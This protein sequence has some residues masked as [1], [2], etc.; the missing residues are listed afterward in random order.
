MSEKPLNQPP[1]NDASAAARIRDA[2]HQA[3]TRLQAAERALMEPIAVI[4]MGCRFPGGAD[5]PD[6]FWERLRDGRDLTREIPAD[7]WDTSALYSDDPTERGK[8]NARRGGFLDAL[9]Q[10]DPA[11]FHLSP[12]EAES[13]DPQQRLVLEVAWEALQHARLDPSAMAAS[14]T[15]I[16]LGMGQND[17]AQRRLYAGDLTQIDVYDGTGNLSCFASGRLGFCLGVHGP[18]LVVDAACSSSLVALHLACQ[19][20]RLSECRTAIAGGVHLVLS[21]EITVFLS[22]AGVLSP[23]GITKTFDADANG[24]VRGEGCGIV[25]LKRLA[26]AQADGD[27]ILALIRGSATNHGGASGGLTVPSERAQQDLIEEALKRSRVSPDEVGYLEAH[28][29][30][31]ALGDPIEVSAIAS[32]FGAS[33]ARPLVIGSVKTN[34]GHLEYAAGVAGVIKA[35][36]MLGHGEIPPH[37]HFRTPNPRIRWRDIAL[38]VP[39]DTRPWPD[40]YK[41]RIAGVSSFGMSGTNAHMIL[42]EPPRAGALSR[43]GTIAPPFRRERYWIDPPAQRPS[44]P[45]GDVHDARPMFCG[46]RL[47]LPYSKEVRFEQ[48]LR[49]DSYPF[50]TDHTLFGQVIVAGASHIAMLLAA[51]AAGLGIETI[52]LEDIFFRTALILAPGEARVV[53]IILEERTGDRIPVKLLSRAEESDDWQLHVTAKIN[54]TA[55]ERP[56]PASVAEVQARFTDRAPGARLYEILKSAGVEM[57]SSFRWNQAYGLLGEEALCRIERP[58]TLRDPQ[59]CP[60]HPGLLDTCFQLQNLFHGVSPA[61]SAAQE[62]VDVPF[63]IQRLRYLGAER[64]MDRLFCLAREEA[65]KKTGTGFRLFDESGTILT[66]VQGFRFRKASR[67]ALRASHAETD[68][69]IYSLAFRPRPLAEEG[70]QQRATGP[71]LIFC[72]QGGVGEA[73]AIRLERGGA[74]VLRVTRALT[75]A[76]EGLDRVALNPFEPADF[77]RLFA[78]GREGRTYQ[79]VLFLWGLDRRVRAAEGRRFEA[80]EDLISTEVSDCETEITFAALNLLKAIPRA[81]SSA[82]RLILATRVGWAAPQTKARSMPANASLWGLGRVIALEHPELKCSLIDLGEGEARELGGR[83]FDEITASDG[84]AQVAYAGPVRHVARFISGL[85]QQGPGSISDRRAIEPLN[86]DGTYLISG[87][88]GAIGVSLARWLAGQG[89]RR[90]V[91]NGR[92]LPSPEATSILQA[93]R[94]DGAEVEVKTGDIGDPIFARGLFAEIDAHG[95]PLRGVFHLAGVVRDLSLVNQTRGSVSVMMRSKV[96]GSVN[97]H[98]LTRDRQLDCFVCFSSVAAVLG[99]RGQGNYAAANAFLEALVHHRRATGLPGVC[100]HWGAWEGAG[101]AAHLDE[102]RRRRL[103]AQGLQTFSFVTGFSALHA[104]MMKNPPSAVVQSLDWELFPEAFYNGDRPSLF[105]EVKELPSAASRDAHAHTERDLGALEGLH[106]AP[107]ARQREMLGALLRDRVAAVLKI[108]SPEQLKPRQPLFDAGLDSITAVELQRDLEKRLR[109]ALSSTLIF[110]YPTLAALENYL[111]TE[112]LGFT[113]VAPSEPSLASVSAVTRH[114]GPDLD[115]LLSGIHAMS[116]EDLAKKLM[117]G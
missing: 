92:N 46:D 74:T 117:H 17:Y 64:P 93:L 42:E 28:G 78:E 3:R 61:D 34:M 103:A 65:D 32:V 91:L 96:A 10:F 33:R 49:I 68:S 38:E 83:L 7:R 53:Q 18:N 113:K 69:L 47:R 72:D 67:S 43:A 14:P 37:L 16:F 85:G 31:T 99:S 106:Q 56:E 94:D 54:L 79:G 98:E 87:G 81:G 84:E 114:E 102:A 9:D 62:L 50:L 66:E 8:I 15:G 22:R 48:R 70:A 11:F 115:T 116:D 13:L 52:V 108:N 41:K 51:A 19:S 44:S 73:L 105:A 6:A 101:M 71:F 1:V 39:T 110:D 111:A 75:F 77:T 58:E 90:L 80:S 20:L 12:R 45:R 60:I 35:I 109:T 86:P 25:V 27:N 29:T 36:L 4:G 57:G 30:G 23:D 89:V 97:L 95:P 5:T 112:V 2:L 82:P 107:P 59:G 24:M 104:L 100:V 55:A 88:L 76:N 40:G 26:D 63:H 21:P